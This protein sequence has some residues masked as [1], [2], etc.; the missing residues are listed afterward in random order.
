MWFLGIFIKHFSVDSKELY[1]NSFNS[2]GKF[3]QF[4][5]PV[6]VANQLEV[7]GLLCCLLNYLV[8]LLSIVTCSHYRVSVYRRCY[9]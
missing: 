5:K 9:D 6:I 4:L 7:L 1:P 8:L 3:I 2:F